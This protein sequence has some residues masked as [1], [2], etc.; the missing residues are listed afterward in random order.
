MPVRI[1][2]FSKPTHYHP[3]PARAASHNGAEWVK[4]DGIPQYDLLTE[5][6]K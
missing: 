2:P 3:K 5:D 1:G 6:K 4:I